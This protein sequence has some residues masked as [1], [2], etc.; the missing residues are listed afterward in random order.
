MVD[1]TRVVVLGAGFGGVSAVSQLA[2]AKRHGA[3]IQVTLVDRNN[4]HAFAPLLYQAAV[5]LVDSQSVAYPVRALTSPLGLDFLRAE[6][7]SIDLPGRRVDTSEGELFFD[8]LIVAL[9]SVPR[10]FGLKDPSKRVLPLKSI[11]DAARIRTAVMSAFEDAERLDDPDERRRRLSF[12]IVGGGPTGLELAGAL[13]ALIKDVAGADYRNFTCS[14][15]TVTVLEA[16]KVVLPGF[17]D[18]LSRQA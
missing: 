2:R 13:Q 12:T 15:A 7:R 11:D 14:E 6:V 18:A 9:G 4:Y 3:P 16:G 8:W 1:R 5:G 17:D 10:Y